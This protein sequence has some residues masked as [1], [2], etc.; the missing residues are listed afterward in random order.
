MSPLYRIA[1]LAC[2]L[3]LLAFA[4]AAHA[5]KVIPLATSGATVT[6]GTDGLCL[7]CS[8]SKPNRI[9]NDN[10][11]D[12][13]SVSIPLGV[14]GSAYVDVRF[15]TPQS[16]TGRVGF[17]LS[18]GGGIVDVTLL[19]GLT[20]TTY[21]G[22]AAQETTG[23]GSLQAYSPP[24][25]PSRSFVHFRPSLPF[26]RVRL[27]VAGAATLLRNV[28]VAYALHSLPNATAEV[29]YLQEPIGASASAE[30]TGLCLGC[31]VDDVENV[32]DR[33]LTR[34]ATLHVPV[35][36][37]GAARVDVQAG[38]T[39]DAGTR[40]GFRLD[41]QVGLVDAVLLGGL[42]L[43]TFLDGAAQETASGGDLRLSNG[44]ARAVSF[45]TSLPYDEVRLQAEGLATALLDLRV[46]VAFAVTRVPVEGLDADDQ[47]A[48]FYDALEE[49]DLEPP[50]D[51]ALAGAT[52]AVRL[53]AP[54]PNPTA[55]RAT[56][57]YELGENAAMRLSV[58]DALGRE[59][60]V[61]AAGVQAAGAHR[62][63]VPAG[64]PPGLYLVRLS[65]DAATTV[66]RLTVAR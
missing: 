12:E 34:F 4:P 18:D 49:D 32:V 39:L 45:T 51:A 48:A 66:Q 13:A 25:E 50:A 6:S 53:A 8:V 47:E 55:G 46:Y 62:A 42:R 41:D 59:V 40:V 24:T 27:T 20:L 56:L 63:D 14:L 17:L 33:K 30:T 44:A 52:A 3:V 65:T 36:V 26:D 38:R 10:L 31:H 16:A 58:F 28:R 23:P 22:D 1:S 57:G 60:A 64:L 61:L 37:A 21:L 7:G 35:G 5:A 29:L 15:G 9:I 43:T 2:L 11:D 19:G 54:V